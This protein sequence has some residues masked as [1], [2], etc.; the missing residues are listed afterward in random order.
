MR[1][2]YAEIGEHQ[3]GGFGHHRA[4]AIGLF[5]L[6]LAA[7]HGWRYRPARTAPAMTEPDM[8]DLHDHRPPVQQD[9]FVAPVE[10]VGF[11]RSKAQRDIGRSSCLP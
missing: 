9:D 11:S 1:F 8:S 10:L 4:A 2:G 3:G 6:L 7:V 5:V